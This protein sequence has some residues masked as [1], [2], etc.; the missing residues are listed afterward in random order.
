MIA[1][2]DTNR[3]LLSDRFKTVDPQLFA[4]LRFAL[5]DTNIEIIPGTSDIWCRDYTP[6]QLSDNS[7]C[8]FTYRP[9]YLKGFEHLITPS[10]R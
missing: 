10:A 4:S 8:Q 3:L 2:W 9:D 7:F 1:E 6:V 5:Q